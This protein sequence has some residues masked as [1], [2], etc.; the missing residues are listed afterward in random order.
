MSN[1][2]S[3][4]FMQEAMLEMY[5][6]QSNTWRNVGYMPMEFAIRLT[7]W[8]PRESVDC[9]GILYWITSAR[10]YVIMG[11]EIETNIWHE[12]SIPMAERLEWATLVSR[13]GKL[14]LVGSGREKDVLIWE[15]GEGNVWCLIG[16]M[17]SELGRK[18]IEGKGSWGNIKCVGGDGFVCLYRNI[19]LEMVVWR[20][21]MEKGR[22][23]WFIVEGCCP[24]RGKQINYPFKGVILHPNAHSIM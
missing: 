1:V 22:W 10:A 4:G 14:T 15:L 18:Y 16:K 19:G 20:E 6:S 12:L 3:S 21:N 7:V 2:P 11:F 8:A 23:E 13:N 17:P 5:D 9:N 24:V